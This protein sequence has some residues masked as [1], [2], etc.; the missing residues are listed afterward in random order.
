MNVLS[1]AGA[2][3]AVVLLLFGIGG[4]VFDAFS[5]IGFEEGSLSAD[6]SALLPFLILLCMIIYI[7]RIAKGD[8]T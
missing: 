8:G 6:L 4:L 3:F 5:L 1:I 7:V 2:I